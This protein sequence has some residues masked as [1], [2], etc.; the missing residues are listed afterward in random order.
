MRPIDTAPYTPAR[1]LARPN[2]HRPGQ[3]P[4]SEKPQQRADIA[5]LTR[6]ARRRRN[7]GLRGVSVRVSVLFR[8]L[9]YWFVIVLSGAVAHYCF[10][11]VPEAGSG[12]IWLMA[13]CTFQLVIAVLG[14]MFAAH[15]RT[16]IIEQLRGF[17]FGY[18]IG[19]GIG[20]AVFM[21]VA[22]NFVAGG[23]EDLF[24]RTAVAALPWI[25]FIPIL[26]P[27]VI[28]LRLVAGFKTIDK[29]GLDDEEIL[30]IYTRNDGRQR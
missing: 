20:V 16:E 5:R 21:W 4:Q 14:T 6:R 19:P 28:F 13:S 18:T 12:G 27:A 23:A 3:P 2:H 10:R 8:Y 22:R 25:Y 15:R 26:V 29:V 7:E 11:S 30:Q 17:L 9:T 24:I 1:T